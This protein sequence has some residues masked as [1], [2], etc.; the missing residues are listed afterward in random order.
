[1]EKLLNIVY[2]QKQEKTC[3]LD[4]YL[5][6][7]DTHP[8]LRR[9]EVGARRPGVSHRNRAFHRKEC[10]SSIRHEIIRYAA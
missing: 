2:D 4:R 1:M 6:E 9:H 3:I 8:V 7:T 5:P 10:C